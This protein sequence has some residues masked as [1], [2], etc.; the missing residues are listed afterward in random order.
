M[1]KGFHIWFCII[2]VSLLFICDVLADGKKLDEAEREAYAEGYAA[3]QQELE[4]AIER[5]RITGFAEGYEQ[6]REEAFE[7][8][9]EAHE[10]PD[11]ITYRFL[12][13]GDE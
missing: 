12:F 2:M 6:G 7:A 3:A 9:R 4:P 8:A 1:K 10:D 13:E 11:S 5:A